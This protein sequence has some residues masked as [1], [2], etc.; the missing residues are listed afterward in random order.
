MHLSK[1]TI[2]NLQ[3]LERWP[4]TWCWLFSIN[5]VIRKKLELHYFPP[6]I[7]ATVY[8]GK[9]VPKLRLHSHEWKERYSV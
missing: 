7:T 5:L 8:I 6:R 4:A 2:L 9:Y 3:S 1:P